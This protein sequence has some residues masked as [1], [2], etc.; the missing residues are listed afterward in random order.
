MKYTGEALKE[1]AFPLGGIGTGSVSL[2]GNGRLTDWE[3]M[4]RPAKGSG[5]GFSHFAIRAVDESGNVNARVL[6]GD[7]PKDIMGQYTKIPFSGYGYGPSNTTMAGF[8]HFKNV[9][10][11][12][13][14]PFANLTFSD[15]AFPGEV[16]LTAFNPLIPLNSDD[17]SLPAAFFE[18]NT[19]NTGAERLT[20]SVAF[21]VMNPFSKTE[22][23]AV[24]QNGL[25]AVK[26]LH[27]GVDAEDPK[28]GD[29]TVSTDVGEGVSVQPYWYRGSWNDGIVTFWNE[30]SSGGE[31]SARN[32]PGEGEKDTASLMVTF[33]LAPGEEKRTRFLLTWNVPNNYNYWKPCKDEN[34]RDITWK[35]YYATR[36]E[37]SVQTA[38]Y[39]LSEWDRLY[40]E[41]MAFHNALFSSSLPKEVVD[42]AAST[43][44]VLKTPTTL[45]L[46]DGAFYGWEGVH[47]EEG[48]CEGTCQHV[49]NYAYAMCFLF[50]DLERSI[51]E[52]EFCYST[53]EDGEMQFRM[54][55][56]RGREAEHFRACL[57][58]QMGSVFK[59]YREW[60]ISG[61]DEWLKKLWPSVKKVLSFAWSD[62][63]PD[64]WDRNK[65]GV[66]EGRQHHTL[67]MELFGPSSWLEGFYLAALKAASEM[68]KYL[69]DTEAAEEY[70]VLFQ[71]GYIWTKEH[72][73]NGK[74]FI[75]S[76]D[77]K[78]KSILE[79]FDALNYWNEEACEMKYQIAGGSEIDQM[80]AQW[81]ANLLGLGDIF[82]PEQVKA[83]LP[84][85]Y[86]N[87]FKHSMRS[88][89]NPWRIFALNDESGAIICDYPQGAYKPVIPIPY[90]EE[91][92]HGFEY[93]LAGLLISE[94]MVEE[95]LSIVRSVRNRY[96]GR[97]RNP[98]NEIECGSNYARS[99]ASFALIPILSGFSFD[100]PH[101]SIGFFPYETE[102]FQSFW[103]VGTGWGTVAVENGETW[104]RL[105]SGEATLSSVSLPYYGSVE[106]LRID[107]KDLP[108]DFRNG[109]LTFPKQTVQKSIQV[110][111]RVK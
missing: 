104:I 93:S 51:R 69:G 4:N 71:K 70:S 20:Y 102:H 94:G 16:T 26:M 49:W 109:I 64:E 12:G 111:G 2:A 55:L 107:G 52:Q 91:S 77:L 15:E 41:T 75:Q 21:S 19:K 25:S 22:N 88:F 13:E 68:A 28:Y 82:D 90:C 37:D 87:N 110:K 105:L 39:A 81:H 101:E 43:L 97:V 1:I 14:F 95:G 96:N 46:E 99:M 54:A 3:I 73:F 35:N 36:F 67:D 108:A 80:L 10:F 24:G 48:S 62:K 76:V 11:D 56:P 74:Y 33:S 61:D 92:M 84:N 98:W 34:G 23:R 58:G 29:I 5:N 40:A 79:H 100:L 83:A 44:S 66:L 18:I 53:N 60:K 30:F 27:F 38:C 86:H 7:H 89:T 72:L 47:E 63:N 42:A 57:D 9:C 45:R 8:P 85:L 32:Y 17:S 78:D 106:A 6:Q 65:D 103:G 50:P 59:T 31:L